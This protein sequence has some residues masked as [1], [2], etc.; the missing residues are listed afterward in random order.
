MFLF[1]NLPDVTAACPP[2]IHGTHSRCTQFVLFMATQGKILYAGDVTAA[3]FEKTATLFT[4]PLSSELRLLVPFSSHQG[5]VPT[6][7][8]SHNPD[9]FVCRQQCDGTKLSVGEVPHVTTSIK[10]HFSKTALAKFSEM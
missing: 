5:Q 1:H 7:L 9:A 3:F 4:L 2:G 10:R 8:E 6:K